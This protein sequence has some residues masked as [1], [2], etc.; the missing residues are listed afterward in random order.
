INASMMA[1]TSA[2]ATSGRR[3]S[4]PCTSVT[5][6]WPSADSGLSSSCIVFPSSFTRSLRIADRMRRID[7]SR[8]LV[9]PGRIETAG[10]KYPHQLQ[11]N[12]LEQGEEGDDEPAALLDV[13]KQ[14][15][16]PAR[17][18]FRKPFEQLLDSHLDRD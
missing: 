15:F 8:A 2:D 7:R 3:L 18:R 12:H 16:E 9:H 14:L 13:G 6:V 4:P 10:L 5:S 1:L 11:S 17:L